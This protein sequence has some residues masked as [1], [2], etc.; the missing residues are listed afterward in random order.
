MDEGR[1]P[2]GQCDGDSG[3][4][5]PPLPRRKQEVLGAA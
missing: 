2:L 1:E 3:A 5:Q 4:D